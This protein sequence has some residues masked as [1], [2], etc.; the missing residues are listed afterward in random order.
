[1]SSAA[2][3]RQF[4]FTLL[5]ASLLALP[6]RSQ[7]NTAGKY[8]SLLWEITGNGLTKPSYLFGTMH[9]SSKMVFHLSDSFYHAIQRCDV[10]ALELNPCL[11]QPD[12]IR[13]E[14]SKRAINAY[15][16][17]ETTDFISEKS[18]QPEKFEDNLRAALTE[19]PTQIN[20]LLYRTLQAQA[21]YEENTYLDL[22]IYQTGR[23]LGKLPGGVEDYYQTEKT[24]FEAY[25]DM[26]KEKNRKKPELEGEQEAEVE[27]KI[28]EA[29][30]K[31]NLDL[32]DSLEMLSFNSPAY[33]EKFLFRRNEIQAHSID[34]IIRKH[35]LFVGVGAAH[36][37]G[38][39]G[40]IELLRKMGYHLR[41]VTMLDRD[42][43][44]KEA[45]DQMKV[46]VVFKKVTT[47][48]G[49]VTMQLPGTLYRRAD[50]RVD[51]AGG[52]W[53][54]ADMDNGAYYMLTRVNTHAA[55]LGCNVND[56]LKKIDSLLYENI[57]GRIIKKT[58]IA[59]N[60]NPGYDITNRTRRGDLQRYNIIVTPFEVM[61]FKMSGND[62]Y[63][64][65]KEAETFFGSIQMQPVEPAAWVQYQPAAG[66]FSVQLPH[67]PHLFRNTSNSD[68]VDRWEYEAVDSAT[69]NTYSIWKKSVH[70][71]HFLEEDTFDI[72]L[73]EESVRRSALVDK[74]VQHS[75]QKRDGYEM[76][77]MQFSIKGGGWLHAAALLRGP[78]YYLLMSKSNSH[79]PDKRYF[80]SF[81]FVPF[82]YAASAWYTD[83]LLHFSVRSPVR[84]VLDT[85]LMNMY[86]ATISEEFLDKVQDRAT[87]WQGARYAGFVSDSTGERI[88]VRM[89][90]YPR[91]YFRRSDTSFWKEELE[92]YR[93]RKLV[94]R[95][96]QPVTVVPGCTGYEQ[97][98]CD[99]NTARI[100]TQ[101][102]LLKGN[103][104]YRIMAI[105]DTL[106]QGS[107]FVNTFF[108]TFTPDTVRIGPSIYENKLNLFLA[109]YFSKDSAVAKKAHDVLSDVYF[110]REGVA[111]LMQIIQRQQY[112]AKDY[113]DQKIRAIAELGYIHDTLV[114]VQVRQYL[115]NLY[116][117][118]GDT[119][120][121][122][123]A[124]LRALAYMKTQDATGAFKTLVLQ[125]P[126]VFESTE[127]YN[128]LF[129]PFADTLK[130][131]RQLFPDLLQLASLEE[132]RVPV[133][134]LLASLAD[135]GLITS[136][137]YDGYYNKLLYDGK[138]AFKRQQARDERLL[139]KQSDD[140]DAGSDDNGEVALR[141]S[142]ELSRITS[143]LVPFYDEYPAVAQYINKLLQS[144]NTGVQLA[145]IKG[146]LKQH[147]PVP[148]SV[149]LSV[150]AQ[151][152]YRS[153]LYAILE[154]EKQTALFPAVWKKPEAMA[155]SQLL[156][157]HNMAKFNAVELM[158]KQLV[159][160]K[161][162]EGYVFLY[163]YKLKQQDNWMIALSGL[164]P[165]D[166]VSVSSNTMLV[167][168]TGKKVKPGI[169]LQEQLD[170]QLKRAL[171]SWHRSAANY[172]EDTNYEQLRNMLKY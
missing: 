157:S 60:G 80:D 44:R 162:E 64:D 3:I 124:I 133:T 5:T 12:M 86:D 53:Q 88:Q 136:K 89:Q 7:K 121:F 130:L 147:K 24:V 134:R 36:L 92:N 4:F 72:K 108:N 170:D 42:A 18:F 77:C 116:N 41:P 26:A 94:L 167:R 55:M 152:G 14:Q 122:Q 17:G 85:Q 137:E 76:L 164:Q 117:A 166:G 73:I 156:S 37:A 84:P 82:Q 2:F 79:V 142:E 58:G 126:P 70:N 172:F 49:A 93:W 67:K 161:Q 169:L 106:E 107:S 56:M 10:V 46:P 129:R 139:N 8:P 51:G 22:Y 160:V 149:L 101:R 52:S 16:E 69:G 83:S 140:D 43:A 48:D 125:D 1:M 112:G 78:H 45:I 99:T 171:Y 38:A 131:G 54:Y 91:Y 11:W 155:R 23:K 165:K 68:H 128:S 63:V 32:L 29:Y 28:Q 154:K 150:A 30:R 66:D 158:G 27:R 15:M 98:L 143:L 148:D 95:S 71:Q 118:V 113:F 74:L 97:V 144:K 75:W 65:G 81:H 135:S 111:P 115:V 13:M 47:E 25:Q 39:R 35:S 50:T 19:E 96:Q 120:Y 31:G 90:Q 146:L 109:D 123:N 138:I 145:A 34:T 61:V 141:S 159:R 110:G 132:Y 104:L 6:A 102:L 33:V 9:V 114:S 20:S 151:D 105:T 163:R 87:Y 119:G 100:I 59:I 57:P 62:N 168:L 103:R 127:G 40:V 21:D 153:D